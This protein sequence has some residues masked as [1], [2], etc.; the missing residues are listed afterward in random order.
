MT[1]K[2]YEVVLYRDAV[3]RRWMTF[4]PTLGG[5]SGDG[6]TRDE[7]LAMTREKIE[8]YLEACPDESAANAL[9]AEL[10]IATVDADAPERES[11][12]ESLLT[13]DDVITPEQA[14]RIRR[15]QELFADVPPSLDLVAELIAERREEARREVLE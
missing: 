11:D 1:T 3:S 14:D 5:I 13:T 6:A 12:A 7:A 15:V 8:G 4:V 9:P 2:S 10:E